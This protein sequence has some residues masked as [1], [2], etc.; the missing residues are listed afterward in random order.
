MKGRA[1]SHGSHSTVT[2][3]PLTTAKHIHQRHTVDQRS[4]GQYIQHPVIISIKIG[5]QTATKS[6]NEQMSDVVGIFKIKCCGVI[7]RSD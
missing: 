1:A 2:V 5:I 3:D 6:R 7:S 4:P